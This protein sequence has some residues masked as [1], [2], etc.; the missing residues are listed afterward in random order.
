MN[1]D[2]RRSEREA[3]AVEDLYRRQSA[4]IGGSGL[5]LR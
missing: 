1:A 4:S 5:R 2:E 3:D